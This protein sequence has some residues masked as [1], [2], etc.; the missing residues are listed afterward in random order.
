[1]AESFLLGNAPIPITDPIARAKRRD[2]FSEKQTD[3]LEGTMSDA[4]VDYISKLVQTVQASATRISIAA[5]VDQSAAISPTDIGGALKAGLYRITYYARITTPAS[6]SSS[7]T[8]S[9]I[10]TD[11]GVSPSVSGAAMTGNTDT[12][13]QTGTYTVRVDSASPINYSTAY[14]SNLAGEMK[15]RLDVFLEVIQ[16]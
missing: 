8:V 14:A 11:G 4:W 1:M 2:R 15:Y 9:F 5:R 16:A 12:T 10:W 6:V 13:I 7:L 3:P